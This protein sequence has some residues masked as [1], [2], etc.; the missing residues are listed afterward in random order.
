MTDN[1]ACSCCGRYDRPDLCVEAVLFNEHEEVLATQRAIPPRINE[2]TL[3]GG[4]VDPG[5]HPVTAVERE[6]R[7]ET[8]LRVLATNG[9]LPYVEEGT[10]RIV[11]PY[12]VELKLPFSIALNDESTDWAWLTPD[13]CYWLTPTQ[14][15][16]VE[17]ARTLRMP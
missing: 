4:H 13:E 3:P 12:V 1:I 16:A 7:E 17:H 10:Q 14:H 8:D 9:L 6:V 15:I 5:E 11:L 2:W